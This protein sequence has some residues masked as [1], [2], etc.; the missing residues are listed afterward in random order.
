MAYRAGFVGLVGLPN[1]GKSSFLNFLLNEHLC[2][3]SS[4]PQATRRRV[5]GV[6]T[7]EDYQI[8]FVDSPGYLSK[9]MNAMTEYIAGEARQVMDD[10]D[11]IVLLIPSDLESPREM[12]KLIES[13]K[14]SGK[15]FLYCMSK[16]DKK[17]SKTVDQ[18]LFNLSGSPGDKGHLGFPLSI[19]KTKREQLKEILKKVSELLPEAEGPMYDQDLYTTERSRD[20]AAEMIR[21]QCFELLDK[22]LPYG[23]GVLVQ[24]FKEE[25]KIVRIEA[26]IIVEREGH[27]GI[28][29]G[30]GGAMLKKIGEGARKKIEK[31]LD[32][33]I[34]LGLHVSHKADWT[35]K[36]HMMKD[37]GYGND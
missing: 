14:A 32:Q 34:Y 10:V 30:K 17:K 3:V 5:Q 33:K 21:E 8:V 31:M 22:E 28:V 4:K 9:S 24:S 20:I 37:M 1:A 13:V 29:I 35:H 18:I 11:A 25:E 36:K 23:L 15:P 19:K 7:G 26:S 12:E 27:K 6:V 2:I 16:A